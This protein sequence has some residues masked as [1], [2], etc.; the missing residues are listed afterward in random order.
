MSSASIRKF[1]D[2]A[3]ALPEHLSAGADTAA[4]LA[5]LPKSSEVENILILGMGTG[6]TA[7]LVVRALGETVIPVPILVG[8]S[9][10]IPACLSAR[11]LVFAV[12]GSGNTDEVNHAAAGSAAL[13]AQIVAVTTGGWLADFAH[14]CGA[15]LIHIPQNIGPARTTFGFVTGALLSAL[16][17]IGFLPKARHW[18][19][20]AN[21][22]LAWRREELRRDGNVAAH[23]ASLL[24]GHHV[25]CQGDT[26]LGAAA[27]ERWKAQINQNA[28]QPASL[29]EQPNASHN[30]A[31]AW[32]SELAREGEAAVLLRHAYEDTRVSRRM[33][34][35]A[36][37]LKGKI[38]VHRVRGEGDTPFAAL[39]D[40]IMIG[41]FTSLHLAAEN[42]VD[43]D[44]VAFISHT[45]KQ[46]L[47]PPPPWKEKA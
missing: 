20:S 40:L 14:D 26:P 6:R 13:G 17:V 36:G 29:S 33:D 44:A 45:V 47:R 31:V 10:A 5:G 7:G 41:D 34:L 1:L 19:E 21:T 39:M 46:G 32:D 4:G 3:S 15:P 8:S 9:Y 28:R 37:Y 24:A 16:Q 23:L 30:E 27:A 2:L 12:S 22:Q 11:S 42:G 38:P 18:I 25:I 35:L 43:P